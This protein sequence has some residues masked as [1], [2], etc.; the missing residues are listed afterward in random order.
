MRIWLVRHQRGGVQSRW[1]FY[2]EPTEAQ[3]APIRQW[4]DR[5]CGPGWL[6]VV[7][8]EVLGREIPDVAMPAPAGAAEE[9]L[10]G[11]GGTPEVT[12]SGTGTV[13]NP[14]LRVVGNKPG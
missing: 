4:L 8:P 3:L 5:Q 7:E 14:P 11:R 2:S 13:R 1:A 10:R 12:I 9:A 6:R